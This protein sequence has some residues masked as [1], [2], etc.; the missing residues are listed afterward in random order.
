MH[1]PRFVYSGLS[2]TGFARPA[3]SDAWVSFVPRHP[4]WRARKG[5]LFA[6]A[7]SMASGGRS[8][9]LSRQV[10]EAVL[11]AYYLD[12]RN[13]PRASLVHAFSEANVRL[14]HQEDAPG[15]GGAAVCALAVLDRRAAVVNVG[16]A[17]AFLVR[18][19]WVL[20]LTADHSW[21]ATHGEGGLSPSRRRFHPRRWD[22]A[23]ALG[24]S[25][26]LVV[27]VQEI[28]LQP[29]DTLVLCS[30]GVADQLT[31][32]EIGASVAAAPGNAAA[33]SLVELANRSGADDC[34]TSVVVRI[35]PPSSMPTPRHAPSKSAAFRLRP[36][37]KS[38]ARRRLL[39]VGAWPIIGALVAIVVL[40]ATVLL[41]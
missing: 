18:P 1:V 13:S 41:A 14:L 33:S 3:G 40:L 6:V 19:P 38:G 15:F 35:L 5:A 24:R 29:G 8:G 10:V 30:D 20:P 26:Q 7:D 11:R 12:G 4:L 2:R 31:P 27:D 16:D 36:N 9:L 28:S 25:P 37:H 22:L 34:M 17:R 21:L 39:D 23:R 32:G